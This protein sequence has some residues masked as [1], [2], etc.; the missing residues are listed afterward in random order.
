MKMKRILSC[1]LLLISAGGFAQTYPVTSITVSLI[2][3]P[4]ANTN[5][6]KSGPSLLSISAS[7]KLINGKVEPQL[8]ES[9]IL[10]TIKK[11]GSKICGS[12]NINSAPAANF[13]SANK[14]WSGN[15]AVSLLGQG[16]TLPPGDYELCVQFYGAPG[17][18]I[19]S[20]EKCKSFTIKAA[21]Q[22]NYL[23]PQNILPSESEIFNTSMATAPVLFRWSSVIP[24]PGEPVNYRLKVWQIEQGQTPTQAININQPLITKDVTTVNQTL[25]T[26]LINPACLAPASCKFVW[27]IQAL[28][29][30]NK[31]FGANNGK[32]E[33]TVFITAQ[34]NASPPIT[35][36]FSCSST[37][38][39][40][41][42]IGDVI[43]LSDDFTMKLTA[44]PTGTN[45]SLTGIGIVRVK[46]LGIFNVKFKGIKI[47]AQDK[48]CSGAIYTNVDSNLVYPTQFLVNAI[49]V[50]NY[51]G[52]WTT[53]KIREISQ[54]IKANHTNKKL[55]AAANQVDTTLTSVPIN[56]PVG[57]F[58]GGD[59]TTSVGFTEM[60]F[61]PDYAEFEAIA[62]WNMDGIFKGINS[63]YG[64]NAI[65]LHG[66]GIKFKSTGL[67]G[68]VGSIKLVEP[69][70]VSYNN[71]GTENLKLTFNKEA[72]GHIGNGMVFSAVNNEFWNYNFDVDVD[73]PKEWLTPVDTTKINVSTNFQMS[74]S[75]WNDFVLQGS[76]PACT[77]PNSN[78]IG[79]ESGMIAFD[80]SYINN[81]SNMVFPT[82]YAGN[83]N[84]MF[85][86]FYMKDFKLTLPDQLRSY[87]DTSKNIQ[88][89]AQ[90]LIIDEYGVSGKI[91]ANN[92]LTFP[93]ANIGNL[94]ASID[95]FSISIANSVITN[96]K[97]LGKI[98]LP[99]SSS[100]DNSSAL[101]YSALFASGSQTSS[102]T[103]ALKP[104]QDITSKFLGDGKI[105]IDQTSSLNL[106]LSK[107][108]TKKRQI[109]FNIDLNGKLYYPAGK[110]IDPGSSIPLDLDLAC[111]FQH[112]GMSYKK[113][114]TDSFSFN[115]GQWSFAS[116]QKKLSGFA[117]TITDVKTKIEP[118]AP[119]AEKQYLFKGGVEFIAKINIGS[120]NSNVGISGDTKI[121]I[122]GAIES[123]KYTPP[124]S[125]SG[126]TTI[127]NLNV[128]TAQVQTQTAINS[129]DPSAISAG[130]KND[131]GF[132]TQLKPK[133]LG[134]RVESINIDAHMA[135]LTIK[136]SVLFYKKDPVYG[137]G[138]KGELQA[139]FTSLNT[140][141]QAGAIFG[142]TKYIPGSGGNGF[143]YWKVEAQVNLPPPGIVFMTGVAFRGF[144]A[145]VYSRMNMTPPVIFN[146]TSAAASTFAG[147]VFT[148][149]LSIKMGFK[150]KAIIATTPKEETFNGSIALGGEFNTSGGMNFIQIDGLFACGAKIGE[151][152][153][154]FA[155]GAIT[156]KY[157]F[158][159][160]IFSMNSLLSIN[161]DPI[162]TPYPIATRLYV[163]SKKNKWYFKSGT[164]EIPMTVSIFGA[165]IQSY[166]MFG[167]DLGT[168]IPK[169][170][171]KETRD[172]FA[173]I[174]YGLP[175]FTE[176]AT[177]DNK[178]QSAKGFA[179]GLGINYKNNGSWNITSF[180]GTI[181]NCDRYLNINYVL[182]AGGEIDASLLQYANCTG[183]G[184]GWRAKMS[185][186]MYA[187]A[188]L[189]YSYSLPVF[190]SASGELGRVT[191]GVYASAEFPNP[192][193]FEGDLKGTFSI[194]GYGVNF[195]SHFKSGDQCG[196][197]EV[198]VDPALEQNVYQQE[199]AA[200]SLNYSL[201][202]NFITPGG[203]NNVARTTD[204]SVLLN[205]PYNQ[206]FDVDEQQSSGQ[207]KV[208][209][210]RASYVVTL[211]QDS[212]TTNATSTMATQAPSLM[213]STVVNQSPSANKPT[214]ATA[215]TL[216]ANGV[217]IMDGGVDALGAKKFK[218]KKSNNIN[219]VNALKGNT[220]YR[221]QIVGRLQ[222]KTGSNWVAVKNKNNNQPIIQTK[223]YWF[224]TNS[225]P[226]NSGVT[227][228]K[229]TVG[230]AKKL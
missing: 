198:T 134:V 65:A 106:I 148:P 225:D 186:A 95:T 112:L 118:I 19:L 47:N 130:V 153:L 17:A 75:Q 6:W 139:K 79:L 61:R 4:D 89:I 135:A 58:K 114:T 215:N 51:G 48:L 199:N 214:L 131:W 150:V 63:F 107:S 25:V 97:M 124:S 120:E 213:N 24:N 192:T 23:K 43:S 227:N 56:M 76:L 57:Y 111:N 20:A 32:S 200:E 115:S 207:I 210:F 179:F 54:S 9:K 161:K 42:A 62:S 13:N 140:T 8:S 96:A 46:W 16:C 149:D 102:I 156:V 219:V 163:D 99:L 38:T 92:V 93:K 208:R 50:N 126:A 88:V 116:P 113:A 129:N 1:F 22:N 224:K 78:G 144:G 40:N 108:I 26:N 154:A 202:K 37:S 3:N 41:F 221:L 44:V 74:I 132:L 201:I 152:A 52:A 82:G 188:I 14:V 84:T 206:P 203:T 85:S 195:N 182:S 77:I 191:S 218:L 155:N 168:D 104:A 5:N 101:N 189:G 39:K 226:V 67:S 167:N 185:M 68:I 91:L 158:P 34:E 66:V 212:S 190:N 103:F 121:A 72:S 205:Y 157:D 159:N 176:T 228:I 177:G 2:S 31:T 145:G 204:F 165:N 36:G 35:A 70:V 178:Y 73:L 110:I 123:D 147:A 169:G 87:E 90:N 53:N 174:G 184:K 194:A 109:E 183:F 33:P 211:T 7:G 166:M 94:G 98:I 60:I 196:G 27:Q 30:N 86:G 193:Y 64:T 230:P 162:S 142:N 222:E 10:V 220:S 172:G 80:H 217:E 171:M 29:S 138:F 143:K 170:F 55:V 180:H 209:T 137:N 117:F 122:T 18:M 21:E 12:Y 181:C 164:P 15:N 151:E 133:Y 229:T 105:Q 128:L 83:T 11:N 197:A 45:D 141:V 119:G 160:K 100:N 187:G 49:N 125:S 69:L 59:T 136:G 81:P 173:S 175:N 71:M 146:P 127:T 28:G 223:N 216:P